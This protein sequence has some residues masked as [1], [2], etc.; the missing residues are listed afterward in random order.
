MAYFNK[1]KLNIRQSTS[2]LLFNTA[3]IGLIIQSLVGP[4]A[5][6]FRLSFYFCFFD[7]I[8]VPIALTSIR[9]AS[10]SLIRQYFIFGCLI[11]IFFLSGSGVLPLKEN[12]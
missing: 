3:F 10:G 6:L 9:E 8:L 1:N 5:E 11:Y 7:I 2:N 12:F 4:I